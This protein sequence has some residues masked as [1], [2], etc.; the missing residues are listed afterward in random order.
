MKL[1]TMLTKILLDK[2][3][4]VNEY[5]TVL[6]VTGSMIPPLEEESEDEIDEP[7]TADTT[8][9]DACLSPIPIGPPTSISI[10]ETNTTSLP[11]KACPELKQRLRNRAE[12][13]V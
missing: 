6:Q 8:I 3:S 5:S 11:I 9:K 10:S 13:K 2:Q 1:I 12:E 4:S 7:I